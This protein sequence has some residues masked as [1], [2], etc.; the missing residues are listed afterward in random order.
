MRTRTYPSF[1]LRIQIH[2]SRVMQVDAY[3][4]EVR[5]EVLV[6]YCLDKYGLLYVH[7]SLYGHVPAEINVLEKPERIFILSY[8]IFFDRYVHLQGN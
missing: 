4:D 2:D 7:R 8:I 3:Y 6:I 5:Y 1:G